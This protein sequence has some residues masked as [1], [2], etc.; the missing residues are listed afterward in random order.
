MRSIREKG[1]W[2]EQRLL[3]WPSNASA[4][5]LR[6]CV[7]VERIAKKRSRAARDFPPKEGRKREERN[8]CTFRQLSNF[9]QQS[10]QRAREQGLEKVTSSLNGG[11]KLSADPPSPTLSGCLSFFIPWSRWFLNLW[12]PCRRSCLNCHDYCKI[13]FSKLWI[14]WQSGTLSSNFD[15]LQVLLPLL[16]RVRRNIR[17]DRF[18]SWSWVILI[19]LRFYRDLRDRGSTLNKYGEQYIYIYYTL[20]ILHIRIVYMNMVD[21]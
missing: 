15:F 11:W 3:Y 9:L 10:S 12:I 1:N 17:V 8:E 7:Y 5:F 14:L 2:L 20:C 6:C 19:L 21:I 13:L 18:F 16:N 4:L